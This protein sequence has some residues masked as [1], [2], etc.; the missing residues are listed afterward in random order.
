MALGI[1]NG[2][3]ILSLLLY[4][5]SDQIL[6]KTALSGDPLKEAGVTDFILVGQLLISSKGEP[7]RN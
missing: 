2:T 7:E 3:Q 1:S 4:L 5:N 6:T